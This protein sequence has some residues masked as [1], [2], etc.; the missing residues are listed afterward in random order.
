MPDIEE[1]VSATQARTLAVTV[2]SPLTTPPPH[3]TTTT[4]TGPVATRET[5]KIGLRNR[6]EFNGKDFYEI[7]NFELSVG[8]VFVL[9]ILYTATQK[10]STKINRASKTEFLIFSCCWTK[11]F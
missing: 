11:L 6:S 5:Q 2:G 9:S 4:T 8:W 1:E 7:E 10:L 3:T